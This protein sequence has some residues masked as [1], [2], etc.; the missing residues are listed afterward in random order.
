M[1]DYGSFCPVS[2]E[3]EAITDRRTPLIIVE[4]DLTGEAIRALLQIHIDGMLANSPAG[5]CH[6]LDLEALRVP[7]ITF[8]SICDEKEVAAVHLYR[9]FGFVTC[10]PFGDYMPDPFSEYFSVSL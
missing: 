4:D 10:E 9:R 6:F 2:L 3:T 7:E 5:S 8:W 1:P